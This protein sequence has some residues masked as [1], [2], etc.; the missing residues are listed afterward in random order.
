MP[1][2]KNIYYLTVQTKT[3]LHVGTVIGANDVSDSLFRRDAHERLVIPGT[4]IAG[5]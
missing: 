4:S 5:W 2:S 1:G 3:A